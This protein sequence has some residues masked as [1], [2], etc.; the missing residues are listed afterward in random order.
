[1]WQMR[2]KISNGLRELNLGR[3]RTKAETMA[4]LLDPFCEQSGELIEAAEI[5]AAWADLEFEYCNVAVALSNLLADP[6]ATE[7][8]GPEETVGGYV[9][10]RW[11]GTLKERKE[12]RSALHGV[13]LEDRMR[14]ELD[15]YRNMIQ[16]REEGV[17]AL[18]WWRERATGEVD[19]LAP[20]KPATNSHGYQALSLLAAQR[21]SVDP[22][23]ILALKLFDGA[24]HRISELCAAEPISR[25][26][27]MMLL[28]FNKDILLRNSQ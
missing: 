5:P 17:D 11:K 24:R 23:V 26:Q 10:R 2:M 3:A 13:T 4:C 16:H 25:V 6:K 1:M 27:M 15:S 14:A 19:P 20:P 8:D 21:H 22:T 9:K 28:R 7:D 12:R 18:D